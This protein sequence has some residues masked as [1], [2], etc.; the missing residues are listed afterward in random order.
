M[1]NPKRANLCVWTDLHNLR[2]ILLKIDGQ[3]F[4]FGSFAVEYDLVDVVWRLPEC[5]IRLLKILEKNEPNWNK[6]SCIIYPQTI[7]YDERKTK[8]GNKSL[9]RM[10][11]ASVDANRKKRIN[12]NRKIRIICSCGDRKENIAYSTKNY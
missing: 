9:A 2:K 12:Y 1:L 10:E 6:F 11:V 4:I 8:S 3:N 5:W 7:I